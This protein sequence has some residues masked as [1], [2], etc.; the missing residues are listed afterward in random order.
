MRIL[1]TVLFALVLGVSAPAFFGATALAQDAGDPPD[2]PAGGGDT[3]GGD[4]EGDDGEGATTD[5]PEESTSE[6]LDVDALRQQYLKLRD[7][8]FRSRARAAAVASA[9]YSTKL[10][11]NLNYTT[12]RFYSV[13]RATIRVDGANVFDDVQGSIASDKATRFEGY[14]APGRHQLSVRI[15]AA[16]K[17]DER[18]TSVIENA[19]VVQAP[20][21]KDVT[22][23]ATAKDEGN[24]PYNWGKKQR[25]S[26]KLHLDIDVNTVERNS[27]KK[28][29]IK[30]K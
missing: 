15:E 11:V 18:F 9:L 17:D 20:A 24:I 23:T 30:R 4:G 27:G 25:G 2:T 14:V 10:S 1:S 6:E 28:N 21:G 3:E 7:Q 5:K 13:T 12:G 16:G 19:F 8:L 29:R 26:Y 22:V